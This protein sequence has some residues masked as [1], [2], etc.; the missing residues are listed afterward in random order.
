MD[1]SHWNYFEW[2]EIARILYAMQ[3]LQSSSSIVIDS[4][5]KPQFAAVII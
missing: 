4:N 3:N 5:M 1:S 2:M